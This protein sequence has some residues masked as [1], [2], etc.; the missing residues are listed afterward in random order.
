MI[1]KDEALPVPSRRRPRWLFGSVDLAVTLLLWL[2]FTIGF[3]ILVGPFYLWGAIFL[4]GRH[5]YF[6]ML[7]HLFYKGFFLLCRLLAPLHAWRIDPAV[8]S[9]RASVIVC[10]HVSFIDSILLISLLPH[11]TTIVKNR[12]FHIP[13]LGWVLTL[14]G[15]LPASAGGKEADLMAARLDSMPAYLAAGGNLFVFPESTRSRD[16]AIG[17]FNAGAFKI[18]RFCRAPLAVLVVRNTE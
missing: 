9:L 8:R 7:N 15:Y 1:S 2:Y 18:A 6:Q 5:G 16:G 12:F 4:R 10:N 3:V 13:I 11:H 14:S 17:P